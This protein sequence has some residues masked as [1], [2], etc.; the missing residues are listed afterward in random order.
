VRSLEDELGRRLTLAPILSKPA[1]RF[2]PIGLFFFVLLVIV[3]GLSWLTN[4][5]RAVPIP[6]QHMLPMTRE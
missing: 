2:V 5:R 4:E 3:I 1:R 6:P